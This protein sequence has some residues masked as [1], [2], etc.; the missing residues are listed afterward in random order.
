MKFDIVGMI[1]GVSLII[2]IVSFFH[3]KLTTRIEFLTNKRYDWLSNVREL[4]DQF[5]ILALEMKEYE[6]RLNKHQSI[7]ENTEKIK[8]MKELQNRI[9]LL[10]N[11]NGMYESLIDI[12]IYRI[13]SISSKKND[14]SQMHFLLMNFESEKNYGEYKN[15]FRECYQN[16]RGMIN[17]QLEELDKLA[18][19]L[20]SGKNNNSF[21]P[22]I[23]RKIHYNVFSEYPTFNYELNFYIIFLTILEKNLIK[24]EWNRIKAEM[25]KLTINSSVDSDEKKFYAVKK[26]LNNNGESILISKQNE[27]IKATNERTKKEFNKNIDEIYEEF[28]RKKSDGRH[29]NEEKMKNDIRME[30]IQA[31]EK[32][33]KET[34]VR[35]TAEIKMI[36]KAIEL[37]ENENK[38]FN[39][40]NELGIKENNSKEIDNDSII[41][42]LN[43]NNI[44]N[45]K[46]EAFMNLLNK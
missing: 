37:I 27:Y 20:D 2:S 40:L 9:S 46:I 31:T 8:K 1:A 42:A 4:F 33:Y 18:I 44:A 36:F 38:I 21:S 7:D 41:E 19:K 16:I 25:K 24:I 22:D 30:L 39:K 11:F 3:T 32:Y 17:N 6:H 26:Y 45:E 10:M 15:E 5:T 43:N 28:K 14:F 35:N 29:T 34:N 13:I 23:L 12:L